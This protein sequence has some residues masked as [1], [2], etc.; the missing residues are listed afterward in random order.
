VTV[1]LGSEGGADRRLI[2]FQQIAERLRTLPGVQIAGVLDHVYPVTGSAAPS[3]RPLRTQTQGAGG[4]P[5]RGELFRVDE[6]YF[7][8]MG[9]GLKRGRSFGSQDRA[10][11]VP[12]AIVAE[13]LADHL[14]PN[15]DPV[16]K[17]VRVESHD[18]SN[19]APWITIVGVVSDV[20]HPLGRGAQPLLYVPYTQDSDPVRW[21]FFVLRTALPAA[22][23]T[24]AVRAAVHEMAPNAM[25]D[26]GSMDVSGFAAQSRF[27]TAMIG[28]FTGLALVLALVGVYGVMHAWVA[29]RVHEIGIR[30]A[31]GARQLDT[32]ILVVGRG[33]K[34]AVIGI[35]CGIAAGVA[36]S[37]MLAREVLGTQ[38]ADPVMIVGLSLVLLGAATLACFVPARQACRIDPTSTLRSE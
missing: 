7:R 35:T 2:T 30:M 34:L 21:R 28:S 32:V 26:T 18:E 23:V 9:I 5:A 20:Y 36:L 8:V 14:W 12:V 15:Q 17:L 11:S 6:Q 38:A 29:E 31:L 19:P 1:E 13:S 25:V 33:V 4:G 10:E 27:V 3:G 24:P 22:T 16:G 37:R